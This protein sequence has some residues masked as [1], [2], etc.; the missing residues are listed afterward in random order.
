MPS[1]RRQIRPGEST[2]FT[3]RV[4]GYQTFL[5]GIPWPYQPDSF[6]PRLSWHIELCCQPDHFAV[7]NGSPIDISAAGALVTVRNVDTIQAAEVFTDYI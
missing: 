4:V 5:Y 3:T 6:F 1:S 2:V 7:G